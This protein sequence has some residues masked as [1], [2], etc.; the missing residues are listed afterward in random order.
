MTT[1]YSFPRITSLFRSELCPDNTDVELL[2]LAKYQLLLAFEHPVPISPRELAGVNANIRRLRERNPHIIILD[3]GTSAPYF[4]VQPGQDPPECV[5]LHTPEGRRIKGWPYHQMLNLSREEALDLLVEEVA[6]RTEGLEVDGFFVD[7]MTSHFDAWALNIESGEPVEVDADEDGKVDDLE[8]LN[9]VWITGKT[10][11]LEK[12]RERF[13]ENAVIC[14]NGQRGCDYARPYVNGAYF[15]DDLDRAVGDPGQWA[16]V[17]RMYLDWC[18]LPHQPN[19]T[20]IGI[21][22][23]LATPYWAKTTSLAYACK[24]FERGHDTLPRMRFGLATALLGNGLFAYDVNTRWRGQRWWY[25]EF[26]APLGK[27]KGPAQEFPDGTWR[28]DFDDGRVIV[29]PGKTPVRLAFE[30]RMRDLSTGWG[31]RGHVLPEA[32]GRIYLPMGEGW[33]FQQQEDLRFQ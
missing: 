13:G 2:R 1:A 7:C 26:D 3:W 33:D 30:S 31:G 4:R 6:R 22:S 11:L 27:E 21:S 20:T 15:E 18:E 9:D 25:A 14:I 28:R 10:R 32:S 17:L 29:N 12:L 24:T 5:F 8:T 23:A 16:D 19:C